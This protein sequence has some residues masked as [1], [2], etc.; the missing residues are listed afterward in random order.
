MQDNR[1]SLEK[2]HSKSSNAKLTLLCLAASLFSSVMIAC[3]AFLD[4]FELNTKFYIIA[5]T[6]VVTFLLSVLCING[7]KKFTR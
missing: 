3:L 1:T 7:L 6:F 5:G 2:S 4:S